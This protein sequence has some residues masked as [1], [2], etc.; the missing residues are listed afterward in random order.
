MSEDVR[1]AARISISTCEHGTV[2]IELLAEDGAPFASCSFDADTALDL[3]ALLRAQLQQWAEGQL[4][5]QRC[6]GHA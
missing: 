3:A 2:T 1:R 4:V 6:A 5:G